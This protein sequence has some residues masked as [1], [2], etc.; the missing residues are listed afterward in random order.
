[1]QQTLKLNSKKQKNYFLAKKKCFIGS[2]TGG[3]LK[4]DMYFQYPKLT[5]VHK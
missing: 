5:S 3:L 1:M 2:A 4:L